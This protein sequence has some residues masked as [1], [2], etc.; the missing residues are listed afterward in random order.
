MACSAFIE[1]VLHGA[2]DIERIVEGMVT[3]KLYDATAFF[4]LT[5]SRRRLVGVARREENRIQ[6]Q[7]YRRASQEQEAP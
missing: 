2:R 5:G 1:W 6:C 4:S 3:A 7:W